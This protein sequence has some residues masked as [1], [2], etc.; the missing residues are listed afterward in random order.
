[1]K[2][3]SISQV[4]SAKFTFLLLFLLACS[5]ERDNP[6]DPKSDF[7]TNKT[8]VSGTCKNRVLV[9]I[10][11]ARIC[12]SSL[13]SET[14]L[15]QTIT[16]ENG[17]YKL[18]QCPAE[19]VLVI[20]EKNGYVAE[21]IYLALNVYKTETLNFTLEG[22]PK[23]LSATISCHCIKQIPL[24]SVILSIKCDLKDDE[25]QGDIAR[26]FA[27]ITGLTDTMPL[28]FKSGYLYENSFR[29]ESLSTNLDNIIGKDIYIVAQDRFFNEVSSSRL[30][31]IRIIRNP[32]EI[33]APAGGEV[34]STRPMLV[35]TQPQYLYQHTYYWEIYRIP[36]PLPPE[37]Y[38]RK[39][40]IDTDDTTYQVTD[41]LI[42]GDYYWQIGIQDEYGN[43]GKSA[44]GV[45]KVDTAHTGNTPRTRIGARVKSTGR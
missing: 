7:Y 10:D 39:D 22:L 30:N 32:P 9:P 36:N 42:P 19:S 41:S 43:T 34:A 28:L 11:N 20:A 4:N 24:D 38:T 2:Y 33:T 23:F 26:V 29:E 8:Q 45:F 27:T 17:T 31:L 5:P 14:P 21:S 12:L 16:N 18:T 37:L 44:E 3:L 35:W 1:M 6:Y 15:L 40:N 25:S 13:D